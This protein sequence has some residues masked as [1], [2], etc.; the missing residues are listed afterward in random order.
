MDKSQLPTPTTP[1]FRNLFRL[2][3]PVAPTSS[4]P[5]LGLRLAAPSTPPPWHCGDG[6]ISG[7]TWDW[8]F[9]EWRAGDSNRGCNEAHGKD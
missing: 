7:T 2:S 8:Q 1:Q 3:F 9:Q 6:G 4:P 5:P